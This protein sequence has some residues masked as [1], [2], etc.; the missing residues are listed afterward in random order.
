MLLTFDEAAHEYRHDG[1]LVPNVTRVLEE[2]VD[3]RFVK[4]EV[5]E[6]ARQLG[7]AVHVGCELIDQGRLDIATVAPV[8]EPYLAAYEKFMREVQPEWHGVEEQVYHPS[9][10]Y[11]GTLDRRG[12]V[13][14]R[15]AILDIKSG[16][17]VKSVGLQTAAYLEAHASTYA[18]PLDS[19]E[20]YAL[21]LDEDG[22]YDLVQIKTSRH[23]D[24]RIF[25]SALNLY[26]WRQL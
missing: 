19:P 5:M 26:N 15:I 10:R 6:R 12:R 14:E 7:R 18:V 9:H 8:V 11:A 20:R 23:N 1:A 4:A 22:T 2:V 16:A 13:R 3:F 21:Y 25:L 17:K 24:F